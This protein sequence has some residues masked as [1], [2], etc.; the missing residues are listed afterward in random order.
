[1]IWSKRIMHLITLLF[2]LS[3]SALVDA[4]QGILDQLDT[5]IENARQEWE[6]P[7]LAIAIVKDDSIIFA[8]GYGLREIGKE[9]RSMSEHCLPLPPTPRRS[10]R[11][12]WAY[13]LNGEKSIG[14]IGSLIICQI[15]RCTI[16]MSLVS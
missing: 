11:R 14:M 8:K 16:P 10:P 2:I 9:A 15:F 4:Q 12:C 5:Y 1:M 7:G 3:A 13:W 6:I